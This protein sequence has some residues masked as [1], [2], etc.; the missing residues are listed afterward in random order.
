[1]KIL[2]RGLFALAFLTITQTQLL[3]TDYLYKDE[4]IFNPKFTQEVNDLGSELYKKSGISLRLVMLKELPHNQSIVEYEKELLATFNE[5]TVLLVFSELNMQVD[6]LAN[7]ESLYKYFD[8]QNVLSPVASKVQAFL[9]GVM[10]AKDW[11]DFKNIMSHSNGTIL[12][13]LGSKTKKH[14]MVG[15]Y[16]A[17]MFNGYLDVA[18]QIAK[19]KNIVLESDYG[20]TNQNTLFIIKIVFYGFVI[21][22]SIMYIRRKIYRMRHKNESK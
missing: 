7:D 18:Q 9:M 16:S 6:I 2:L 13:L 8:K 11:D 1:M 17:S 14:E 21:Y 3:A 4:I 20:E 22:A 5:P 15:K 12:P 10:Y 19:S